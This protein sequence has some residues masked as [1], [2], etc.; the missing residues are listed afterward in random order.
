MIRIGS[1]PVLQKY[2]N[3][4]IQE[5]A[6]SFNLTVTLP[7]FTLKKK[8]PYLHHKDIITPPLVGLN[9]SQCTS[10]TSQFWTSL[11]N[12]LGITL[13]Q[14]TAYNPS[15]NG[16]VERFHRTLK[17]ALMKRCTDFN[18]IP[19][20]SWVFL[21]Q[22]T[23]LKHALDVSAAEMLYGDPLVIP[24]Q[25]FSL[26]TSSENLQNKS[27]V[28]GKF[29]PCHQT[30]KPTVK[31]HILIDLLMASHIFLCNGNIKPPLRFIIF[32]DI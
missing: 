25:F 29:T 13:Y 8:D 1:A 18:W 21:G 10:F 26:A 27:H 14:T 12:F 7:A 4:W 15:A 32:Q 20:F 17:A 19:Q 16:M 5:W 2:L 9:P 11:V 23:R 6:L 22:R 28:V 31:Q 24:A 30:Y 3:T